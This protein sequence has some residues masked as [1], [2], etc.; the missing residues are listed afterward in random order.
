MLSENHSELHFQSKYHLLFH[1]GKR[2]YLR[3]HLHIQEVKI[4]IISDSLFY[5]KIRRY[6]QQ[7]IKIGKLANIKVIISSFFSS[8]LSAYLYL[9]TIVPMTNK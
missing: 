3:Y 5:Q 4:Q 7:K 9:Y 8:L 6:K 2:L 1:I